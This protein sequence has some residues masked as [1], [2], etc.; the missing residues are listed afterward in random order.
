MAIAL[1]VRKYIETGTN[2]CY[3]YLNISHKVILSL[4]YIIIQQLTQNAI[5]RL[6]HPT[7]KHAAPMTLTSLV[8]W[9]RVIVTQMMNALVT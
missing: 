4:P 9:E 2:I 1:L 5:L 8:V 7:A 3:R 6:G